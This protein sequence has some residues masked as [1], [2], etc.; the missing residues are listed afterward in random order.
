ML[1]LDR[2]KVINDSLGH[3]AGDE[4][5]L[6][7]APRLQEAMRPSDTVARLGGDEFVVVCEGLDGPRDAVAVAER[8]ARTVG[9]P[10]RLRSGEHRVSVSVGIAVAAHV[11]DEPESLLRDADAALYRAKERGRGRYELFD[12]PM[13]EQAIR[14][15]RVEHELRRALERGELRVHYQPLVE[16]PTR[17][18]V[19]ME[20][21]VRWQH[22]QR[23]L[24]A[25]GEF[26]TVAEETGLISELG[27]WVLRESCA[28]VAVWQQ[29]HGVPIGLCVNVSGRQIA[30]PAFAAQ[31]SEI[32]A[33]SGLARDSLGLEI[34]ESVLI[35]EAEAPMTVLADLRARDLHLVLDDFGTGYSSLSYLQRFPLD[36]LKIDRSF[37]QGLDAGDEAAITEAIIRMAHGLNLDV[38]AEGV[39]TERQAEIL[40]GL[41]CTHAQGFLFARPLP[42]AGMA[43]YL[44]KVPPLPP[45][46]RERR[47]AVP[48][49]A[50]V[51]R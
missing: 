6:A 36:G 29:L 9:R 13:R 31:V 30:Q 41:G 12:E 4:L 42:A 25:P 2:F 26:I 47:P 23:G 1:D 17:R 27:L 19:G 3:A 50:R 8:I 35:D 34:T 39:E 16:L 14:R 33:A 11:G 45:W 48:R 38:V 40:A 18:P 7:L 46:Q 43:D 21:L 15:M 37:V 49:S 5:L 28:Q 44:A 24:I 10:I 22:P 20:A 32:V 51:L